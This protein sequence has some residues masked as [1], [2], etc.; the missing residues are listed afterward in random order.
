MELSGQ[1]LCK[2]IQIRV[3]PAHKNFHVCHCSTCVQWGGGP[4]FAID[5]ATDV[6]FN[7]EDHIAT[8]ASSHWAS[9]GF[10]SS[11]GTHLFYRFNEN[12]QMIIPTGL[13]TLPKD[14]VLDAQIFIDHKPNYYSLANETQMLT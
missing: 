13:F 7:G 10:C 8:Y 3:K 4:L 9:R 11:C 14:F 5:C 1:C 6:S 2:K 12:G